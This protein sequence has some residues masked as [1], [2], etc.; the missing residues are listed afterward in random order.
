M[1]YGRDSHTATLVGNS[2]VLLVSGG[3]N[4]GTNR[5]ES[6]DLATTPL[7]WT[8]SSPM[9]VS[10]A[11]HT[12]TYIPSTDKV[13]VIGGYNATSQ[14]LTSTELFTLTASTPPSGTWSTTGNKELTLARAMHT[15]TLLSN[16]NV[17]V[18]GTY[19]TTS[20]TVSNTTE[21]WSP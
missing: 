7:A 9:S 6:L 5:V 17:L 2:N 13:L 21:I 11:L 1:T 20:G 15:S 19:Y 8:T 14:M 16:G 4:A 12:S 10:R 18:L 3:Y